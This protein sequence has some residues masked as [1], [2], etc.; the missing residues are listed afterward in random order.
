MNSSQ[1]TDEKPA[2][3]VAHLLP[4]A[5]IEMNKVEQNGETRRRTKLYKPNNNFGAFKHE[6]A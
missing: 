3:T 5:T 2:S 4:Q 6:F 1:N